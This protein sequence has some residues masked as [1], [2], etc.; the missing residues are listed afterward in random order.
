MQ[1]QVVF[2]RLVYPMA[3]A[4]EVLALFGEYGPEAPDDLDLG[5]VLAIPPGGQ[6]GVA[7]VL[8]CYSGPASGADRALAR[9]RRLGTPLADDIKAM[10][11]VAVQRSGDVSDPRAE[12]SY[13]KS[14]F[15]AKFPPELVSAIVDRL[16]GH[17]Q[18]STAVF[19][20]L[21]RGA[22]ARVPS[23]ATAFAQ[24]DVLA[25]MLSA[26]GWKHGDDPTAHIQWIRQFWA[27]LEPFTHGF[28]VND[29]ESDHSATAIR[30]NYRRNHDRL[31]AVKNKY[32]PTNLFRLNANVKPTAR[33]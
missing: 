14:G 2:G 28:Y 24:R 7:M 6:P 22:I 12:G 31:V 30:D 26:V 13:L 27:G 19:F 33:A 15:I 32:D 18:R 23:N 21:G 25:N 10:D 20:Q 29:L 4:K 16:E 9:I 11:Y 1:R 5:C 17:P 8:V 3:K